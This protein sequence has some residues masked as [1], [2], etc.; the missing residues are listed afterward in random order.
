MENISKQNNITKL[1]FKISLYLYVCTIFLG[2][3]TA[4]ISFFLGGSTIFILYYFPS[5]IIIL[6]Y[7]FPKIKKLKKI[8]LNNELFYFCCFSLLYIIYFQFI[9]EN[10]DNITDFLGVK[11]NL[12]VFQWIAIVP[13]FIVAYYFSQS[14]F[15]KT[16]K[17]LVELIWI[18]FL[19]NYILSITVLI[20]EPTVARILATGSGDN[21]SYS[22]KGV[23]GFSI[24]YSSVVMIPILMYAIQT[25]KFKFK[26]IN[27]TFLILLFLFL[28]NASFTSAI[29]ISFLSIL[30]YLLF[31]C[32]NR[33]RFFLII[34]LIVISILLF[35]GQLIYNLFIS[36]SKSINNYEI[37]V[38]FQDIANLFLTNEIGNGS[39]GLRIL[40]YLNSITAFIRYPLFGILPF[41]TTYKL[42]G[43]ST[44][45]DIL[46]GMGIIG[47]IPLVLGLYYSFKK[48]TF[49]K[50]KR[51]SSVILCSYIVFIVVS[52]FNPQLSSPAVITTLLIVIPI[53]MEYINEK[54]RIN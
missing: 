33:I 47:F 7:F 24:V 34:P 41:D 14:P 28:L 15:N 40:L 35:D 48:V 26:L 38:R 9:L 43:H 10:Q 21:T 19:V 18:I 27:F 17:R 54:N 22:L 45:L 13:V 3:F 53:S 11:V 49:K 16:K 6:C 52:I 39:M 29:I 5:I 42:S 20:E 23:V 30:L 25:M 1:I 44:I 32:N 46:G 50:N 4:N 8:K 2:I 37:S 31:L 36:L 12:N 51:Y